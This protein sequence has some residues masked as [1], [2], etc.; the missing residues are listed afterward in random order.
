MPKNF[1]G[2]QRVKIGIWLLLYQGPL[3]LGPPK[4][5][6][7]TLG[8]CVLCGQFL[9]VGVWVNLREK[10]VPTGAIV[11]QVGT[12]YFKMTTIAGGRG[13]EEN[14]CGRT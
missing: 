5:P 4:G 3:P 13:Q 9:A 12:L 2:A 10:G 1:E 8:R 11:T 6:T 7:S 14:R